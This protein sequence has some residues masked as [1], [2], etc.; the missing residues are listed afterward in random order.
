MAQLND[1]A[2]VSEQ[3]KMQVAPVGIRCLAEHMIAMGYLADATI[4]D[5]EGSIEISAVAGDFGH[6]VFYEGSRQE[7]T[8]PFTAFSIR[9]GSSPFS[10]GYGPKGDLYFYLEFAGTTHKN[11]TEEF[12]D[13]VHTITYLYP[14]LVVA[15]HN[16]KRKR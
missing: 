12:L 1:I 10:L 11:V 13:R 3:T 5:H 4:R 7:S 15:K 16:P 8:T 14:L 2:I 6:A 9:Y